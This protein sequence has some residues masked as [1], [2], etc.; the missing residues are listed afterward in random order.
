MIK[1]PLVEAQNIFFEKAGRAI[2]SS[3]N[4][5]LNEGDIVHRHLQDGDFVLYESGTVLCDL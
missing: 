1:K 2:L 5:T 3:V 4:M